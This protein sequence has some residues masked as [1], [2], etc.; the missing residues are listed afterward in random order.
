MSDL[1]VCSDSSS[2]HDGFLHYEEEIRTAEKKMALPEGANGYIACVG[3]MILGGDIFD[4]TE[5]LQKKWRRLIQ[6][7]II[8]SVRI[9]N[10]H[11]KPV[12]K[13][14]VESFLKNAA[15]S[16]SDTFT[17]VGM[18][19]GINITGKYVVGSVLADDENIVHTSIFQRIV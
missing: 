18:G 13:P 2:M 6:G 8:E 9:R 4:R 19:I 10:H 14:A 3:D 1:G 7:A 15:D 5:T 12:E 17:P 11:K 16:V